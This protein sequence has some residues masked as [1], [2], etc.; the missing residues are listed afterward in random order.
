MQLA[1]LTP[2]HFPIE[3]N[4]HCLIYSVLCVFEKE[5]VTEIVIVVADNGGYNFTHCTNILIA[6]FWFL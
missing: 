4:W 2:G 6:I 5:V 1:V 3:T